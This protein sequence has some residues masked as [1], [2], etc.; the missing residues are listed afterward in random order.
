MQLMLL[1]NVPCTMLGIHIF[2]EYFL[3]HYHILFPNFRYTVNSFY[4]YSSDTVKNKAFS[5]RIDFHVLNI[6]MLGIQ[7]E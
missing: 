4:Q 5:C 6:S 3:S 7:S 1:G 2:N